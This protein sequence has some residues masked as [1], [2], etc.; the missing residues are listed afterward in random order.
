MAKSMCPRCCA[1]GFEIVTHK[2]DGS[3]ISI[4]LVQCSACGSVVG[5]VPLHDV[6]HIVAEFGDGFETD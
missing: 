4:N 3:P 1:N 5:V 2:P 6:A